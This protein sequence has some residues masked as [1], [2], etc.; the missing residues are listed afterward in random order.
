MHLSVVYDD[1]MLIILTVPAALIFNIIFNE[2]KMCMLC[3]TMA[4]HVNHIKNYIPYTRQ[5]H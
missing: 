5:F 4:M 3:L 1:I 2:I